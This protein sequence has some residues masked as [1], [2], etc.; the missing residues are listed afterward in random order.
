MGV[1]ERNRMDHNKLDG[2]WDG[3]ITYEQQRENMIR[4]QENNVQEAMKRIRE[5]Q[6]QAK[7]ATKPAQEKD[8]SGRSLKESGT[9]A[10]L[11]KTCVVRGCLHYFPR[12]LHAV[13]E[14]STIGSRKYSWKGWE[15][16]PDGV[17]RY[18][19]AL[20]R[21]ELRIEGDYSRR[22]PDTGV[23]EA[24]AV[25]WNA[26]ARLELLLRD[27]E[28]TSETYRINEERLQHALHPER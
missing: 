24:T 19:D 22:D 20:G 9:K 8:P 3:W 17:N 26:L 23:L 6:A 16:V 11:G 7:Q 12:A 14:L 21:H 27:A 1:T 28:K 5:E 4:T 13:A 25:C 15:S 2:G 18:A 10:D